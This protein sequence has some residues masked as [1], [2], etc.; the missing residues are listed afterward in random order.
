MHGVLVVHYHRSKVNLVFRIRFESVL[1]KIPIIQ[2][3]GTTAIH[4]FNIQIILK[5]FSMPPVAQLTR[6]AHVAG[7]KWFVLV[8][9]FIG[10]HLQPHRRHRA[11]RLLQFVQ[12]L[13]DARLPPGHPENYASLRPSRECA[14]AP[15]ELGVRLHHLQ[16]G[17]SCSNQCAASK[18]SI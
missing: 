2:L 3:L 4:V 13:H 1:S 18:L 5:L 12:A 7:A 6:Q 10:S 17:A 15:R 14:H 9:V 11:P 16:G 8:H